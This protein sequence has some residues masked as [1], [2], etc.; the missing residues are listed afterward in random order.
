M[1][2]PKVCIIILNWNG[3][4][5]TVECLESLKKLTYPSYDIIV[6][7]N[8]SSG[9][10]V[11][12]LRG[13]YG[14]YIHI[15]QN[16]KNYGFA[17]GNNIGIRYALAHLAPDYVFLLNNDT[18]VAPD[19]LDELTKA[20]EDDPN[21]G[22]VGPKIYYYDINGRKDVIWSAGGKIRWWHPW[23]YDG[24]GCNDDDLPQYQVLRAVDWVSGAAMMVKRRVLDEI[25]LLNGDYFLGNEDVEYCLKAR[26]HGFRVIY[27][28]SAR[29]WHK[30][31]KSRQ[32]HGPQLS[33]LPSYYRLVRRNF[34][35]PV[36]IYQILLAPVLVAR[37]LLF[38]LTT[39]RPGRSRRKPAP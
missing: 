25:S 36:Y 8:A 14:D 22:I 5:D 27:V 12:V 26:K 23:V 7:D 10:D 21:T 3:L 34:P 13:R 15:I 11:E 33:D 32:K 4:A 1:T 31:G 6:V 35:L 20:A 9:N 28:P 39:I 19:V 24:I 17:E 18:L 30:V 16:D 37:R 2:K 38:S 29:L